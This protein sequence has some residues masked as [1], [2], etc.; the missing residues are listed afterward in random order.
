MVSM[1]YALREALSI[2]QEEGLDN[3]W[4]RWARPA[5]SLK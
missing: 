3:M 1:C 4:S 2:V 5:W